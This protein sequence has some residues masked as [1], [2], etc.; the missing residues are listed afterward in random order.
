MRRLRAGITIIVIMLLVPF[1]A[2][3]KKE[4]TSKENIGVIDVQKA[5]LTHPLYPAWKMALDNER[6][7]QKLKDDHVE[8]VK[9]QT[10]AII[11][12]QE[13]E[14]AGKKSYLQADY[15][16]KMTEAQLEERERLN[17]IKRMERKRIADTMQG[18]FDAIEEE[19]KLPLFNLKMAIEAVK[20]LPRTREEGKQR[21]ENLKNDLQKMQAE[22]ETK[23][24]KLYE[25]IDGRLNEAMKR[26]ENE[27]RERLREKAQVL[28]SQMTGIDA[29]NLRS[30]EERNANI[31]ESFNR[32]LESLDKQLIEQKQAKEK[33]YTRM[34]DEIAS[35]TT[36][37][38]IE[39]NMTAVLLNV[40]HNISAEDIT[41]QVIS[42]IDKN[43]QK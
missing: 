11:K 41:D 24:S 15:A 13:L 12:M 42:Y 35:I 3:C 25:N 17:E 43:K 6:S 29:A 31:P 20:P 5:I 18:Q 33:L 8:M 27:S 1:F 4:I 19:Y 37:I 9:K 2:G 30:Q 36:K 14:R 40:K 26:H 7:A 39:K 22:K 16:I 32:T 34:Y 21:L 38:A 10:L 28:Y 23:I